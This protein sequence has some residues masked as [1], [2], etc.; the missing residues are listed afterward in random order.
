MRAVVLTASP[1]LDGTGEGVQF[2]VEE[3]GETEKAAW[4]RDW[5]AMPAWT[6]M[7]DRTVLPLICRRRVDLGESDADLAMER[8][9]SALCRLKAGFFDLPLSGEKESFESG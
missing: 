9:N 2:T 8:K 4:K 3:M 5:T 6:V 1:G 7:P